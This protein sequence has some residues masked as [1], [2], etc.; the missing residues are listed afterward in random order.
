MGWICYLRGSST[1]FSC[2]SCPVSSLETL[3]KTTTCPVGP[4][5]A[6]TS[7]S[8]ALF[9]WAGRTV[10]VSKELRTKG[11]SSQGKELPEAACSPVEEASLIS[12]GAWVRGLGQ[13]FLPHHPPWLVPSPAVTGAPGTTGTLSEQWGVREWAKDGV[14]R[15]LDSRPSLLSI[16]ELPPSGSRR[17]QALLS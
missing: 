14:S 1:Q 4:A 12:L 13:H 10:E 17:G 2:F 3:R 7:P 15:H 5:E 6:S 16:L 8:F 9:S 11:S